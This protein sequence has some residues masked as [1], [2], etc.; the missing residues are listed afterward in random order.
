MRIMIGT[1]EKNVKW[2][3]CSVQKTAA[4][5]NLYKMIFGGVMAAMVFVMTFVNIPI[6]TPAGPSMLKLGNAVC[7][8]S[9]LLFGGWIGGL[10]AGIG[11]MIFD[12]TNPLFVASAPFTFAFYFLMAFVCGTVAHAGGAAGGKLGRNIAAA[13]LGAALYFTLHIG[14]NVIELMLA[15]SA[16]LP[17]LLANSTRMVTSSING[18]AGIALSVVL[19]APLRAALKK[20]GLLARIGK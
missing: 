10:A 16:F 9:G 15:G 11:C 8:L 18:A 7:L 5:Q 13:A 2:E 4:R 12:L 1:D 19:A 20:G 14:K 3:G 6:A 17:A